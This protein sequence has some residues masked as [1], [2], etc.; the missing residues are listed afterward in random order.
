M[1]YDEKLRIMVSFPIDDDAC[2]EYENMY[3]VPLGGGG[4][5]LDNS[6]FYVFGISCGDS[7]EA[8]RHDGRLI[9]SKVLKRGGHS[10]YRIK[11]PIGADHGYFL[12]HWQPLLRLGCTYEGSSGGGARLYSVDMGPVVDVAAAYALMDKKERDG[13]WFFEEGH[14]YKPDEK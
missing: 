7:F 5:C 12:L 9:F 1:D 13:V 6:P 10:T 2:G 8:V 14:Y 3:A 4:F 11:L